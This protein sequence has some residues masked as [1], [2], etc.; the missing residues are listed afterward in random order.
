MSKV[1]VDVWLPYYK[2]G[3]DLHS[4]L[5]GSTPWEAM[6]KHANLLECAKN[7]LEKIADYIEG[8]DVEVYADTHLIGLEL[9]KEIADILVKEG[10]ATIPEWIDEEYEGEQS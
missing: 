10:L 4:C 2:Q 3:D 8:K 9:N 6:R 5:E 1:N 7:T